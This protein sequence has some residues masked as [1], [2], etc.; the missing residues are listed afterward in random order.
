MSVIDF[1]MYGD[2]DAKTRAGIVVDSLD[3][4]PKFKLE[5]GKGT[6]FMDVRETEVDDSNVKAIEK[7]LQEWRAGTIKPVYIHFAEPTIVTKRKC[8]IITSFVQCLT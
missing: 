7:C 3:A 1:I 2:A 4:Q 6:S 5:E 8:N